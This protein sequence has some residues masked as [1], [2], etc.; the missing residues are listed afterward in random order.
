LNVHYLRPPLLLLE[1]ETELLDERLVL[2]LNPPVLRVLVLGRV[3]LGFVEPPKGV[4]GFVVGDF[5][6]CCGA[7]GFVVG[8]GFVPFPTLPENG[9][10]ADLRAAV[11]LGRISRPLEM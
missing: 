3:V 8:V 9:R 2:L 11:S 1:R 6:A 5:G 7:A 10:P 4:D